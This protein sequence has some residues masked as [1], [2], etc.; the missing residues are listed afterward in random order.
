[1]HADLHWLD[2]DVEHDVLNVFMH[3]KVANFLNI[4]LSFVSGIPMQAFLR[5]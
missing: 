2:V 4:L 5:L 3:Q 1:M